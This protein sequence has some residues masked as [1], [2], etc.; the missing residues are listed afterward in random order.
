MTDF[1]VKLQEAD[2]DWDQVAEKT[3]EMYDKAMT[4]LQGE[5]GQ[6][7]L[8]KIQAFSSRGSSTSRPCWPQ[9]ENVPLKT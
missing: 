8:A 4:Y 6:G 7:L 1:R 9:A 5:E 3:G 2:I